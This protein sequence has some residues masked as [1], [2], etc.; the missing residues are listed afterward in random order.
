MAIATSSGDRAFEVKTTPHSR[1]MSMFNHV[2]KGSDVQNGK[3]A[4]DIF[5]ECKNRFENGQ[6]I[7]PGNCLAFE[8]SPNGV[9]AAKAAN[10]FT[11]MIP[12]VR[13]PEH[14]SQDADLRLASMHDLKPELFGLPPYDYK[15]VTHVIFD[16]DGLLLDTTK[17]YSQVSA[18]FLKRFNKE[19]SHQLKMELM[20]KRYDDIVPR[21]I[22]FYDLPISVEDYKREFRELILPRVRECTQ[23]LPGVERFIRH[24][25][26]HNVPMAVATSSAKEGFEAKTS[27]FQDLFGL[28]SHVVNGS[29]PELMHGK[30]SPDI[31]KLAADRFTS[32]PEG[33]GSCLVFEDAPNGVQAAQSAGMQS[34]MIPERN[35]VDPELTLPATQLLSSMEEI[36][37]EDFG[38]PKFD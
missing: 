24:L 18:I 1:K 22:E 7:N 34:V 2:V 15:P 9:K 12:D 28:F 21:V 14:L 4:P 16:M 29:D 19:P 38:L 25:H 20:G 6:D 13:M 11:V 32:K 17:A 23:L 10:M 27:K 36:R 30:P 5:T 37:P 35:L 33:Y 3:P 31:F 26:K 8:D